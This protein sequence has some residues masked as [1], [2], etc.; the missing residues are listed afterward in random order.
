MASHKQNL[1]SACGSPLRTDGYCLMPHCVNGWSQ[2]EKATRHM[3]VVSDELKR[4][5]VRSTP[6][7]PQEVVVVPPPRS[8]SGPDPPT[9]H[10]PVSVSADAPVARSAPRP[11][12]SRRATRLTGLARVDARSVPLEPRRP[13]PFEPARGPSIRRILALV[14]VTVIVIATLVFLPLRLQLE[15]TRAEADHASVCPDA[16]QVDAGMR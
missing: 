7:P 2:E 12:P 14:L 3:P 6:P 4:S 13:E 11:V 16:S 15:W 5:A 9:D 1:C 8:V 10:V